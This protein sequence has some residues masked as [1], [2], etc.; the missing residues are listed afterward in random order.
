MPCAAVCAQSLSGCRKT[1][2]GFVLGVIWTNSPHIVTR[3]MMCHTHVLCGT[4]H[5][6]VVAAVICAR[7]TVM[8]FM[9][10]GIMCGSAGN[11][12]LARVVGFSWEDS[13]PLRCTRQYNIA[14]DSCVI[15]VCAQHMA[16]SQLVV[17]CSILLYVGPSATGGADVM[18]CLG[19][20]GL[21]HSTHCSLIW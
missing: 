3:I 17:C 16:Q 1:Q 14:A 11:R 4:Q 12:G 5:G 2:L 21:L 9:S 20:S 13:L 6:A 10:P 19:P 8:D 7:H 18:R 15:E